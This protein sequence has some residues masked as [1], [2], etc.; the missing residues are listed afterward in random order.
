[1]DWDLKPSNMLVQY[2]KT[3][4]KYNA[5]H[6]WKLF[7]KFVDFGVSQYI[8]EPPE[9]AIGMSVWQV[10]ETLQGLD[11]ASNVYSLGMV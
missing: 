5:P 7:I 9:N 3:M 6:H 11:F 1:M 8:S 10:P 4:R 2:N